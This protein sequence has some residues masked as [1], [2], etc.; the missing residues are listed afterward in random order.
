MAVCGDYGGYS[1]L[2]VS[3]HRVCFIVCMTAPTISKSTGDKNMTPY[4]NIVKGF[5]EH[6]GLLY[7]RICNSVEETERAVMEFKW[8]DCVYIVK[9]ARS[10]IKHVRT[11]HGYWTEA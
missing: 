4:R 3:W 8:C 6:G 9:S 5:G 1:L 7:S 11:A 2:S 10:A